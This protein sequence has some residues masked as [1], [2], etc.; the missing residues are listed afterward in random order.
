[1][2]YAVEWWLAAT[3]GGRSDVEL[4]PSSFEMRIR[5]LV[6]ALIRSCA[7]ELEEE[8]QQNA[9]LQHFLLLRPCCAPLPRECRLVGHLNHLLVPATAPPSIAGDPH[10]CSAA[11]LFQAFAAFPTCKAQPQGAQQ[12][13]LQCTR[14]LTSCMPAAA[15]QAGTQPNV[16]DCSQLL[17]LH[18]ASALLRG[19]GLTGDQPQ[20]QRLLK[21]V[22]GGGRAGGGG[23]RWGHAAC[24]AARPAS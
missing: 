10:C 14:A 4:S 16:A 23:C 17:L 5:G 1:M 18:E 21:L 24:A 19:V 15:M 8:A 6:M 9:S 13:F 3:R 2:Q 20:L 7:L 22:S 11:C 12:L